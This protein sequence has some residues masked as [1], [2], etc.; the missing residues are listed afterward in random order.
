M[1][2]MIP[3]LNWV[4][5]DFEKERN[6]VRRAV[7]LSRSDAEWRRL[8]KGRATLYLSEKLLPRLNKSN[9]FSLDRLLGSQMRQIVDAIGRY[10][11]LEEMVASKLVFAAIATL[12]IA[13]ISIAFETLYFMIPIFFFVFIF[14]GFRDVRGSFLKMQREITKD[15][16]KLIEKMMMALE[17]G[18]SFVIVFRELE[19]S[20]G[21]RMKK[22]LNRL[23]ANLQDMDHA[24]AIEIFARETTIPV[25]LQFSN[26]VKIGINSGYEDAKDHFDDIRTEILSLRKTALIEITRSRPDRVKLLQF[27]IIGCSVGSVVICFINIFSAAGSVF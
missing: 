26:A 25:M 21:Q 5:P 27:A 6:A 20:S 2:F 12:P 17:T 3:I 13:I 19:L 4:I 23:N 15:L 8:K 24:A 18:K 16:P 10:D 14:K 1:A 22:M 9:F 7:H 11:S